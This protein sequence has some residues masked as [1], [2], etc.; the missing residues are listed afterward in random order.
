MRKLFLI[1]ISF[2]TATTFGQ[3]NTLYSV[4]MVEAKMGQ[5]AA[6]VRSWKAHVLKFHNGEDKRSVEEIVTGPNSGNLLLVSG[7]SSIADM[8]I[9]KASQPAHDADYDGT[10]VPSVSTFSRMG[11]Y[12][13]VDTL[14][15]N[16]RVPSTKYSTTIYHL[17]PGKAPELIAEIKRALAVNQKI[18]S[19]S[20]YNTYIK[21]W[22]GSDPVIVIRTNLKD[23]FKQIDNAYPEMKMMTDNFKTAYIQEYGQAMWDNRGKLLPE[24]C[25]S[26]ENYLSK[27]RKDL[28]SVSK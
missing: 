17:K 1:A 10:V 8:D 25:T 28:S 9:E 24:I 4:S 7:P 6:F 27:D 26:W 3:G 13:W 22:A 15:Y 2:A 18:K 19:A 12:R 20:S 14:S 21:L 16:G 11:A 23:G 5:S